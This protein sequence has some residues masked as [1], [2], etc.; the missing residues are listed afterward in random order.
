MDNRGE[1]ET[2]NERRQRLGGIPQ[3][4]YVCGKCYEH[5]LMIGMQ[6]VAGKLICP[7]CRQETES[8]EKLEN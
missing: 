1:W 2:I 6:Q 8:P 5:A 3:P 7:V 4:R